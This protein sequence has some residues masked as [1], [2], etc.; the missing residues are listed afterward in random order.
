[1]KP[2]S[3]I[4]LTAALAL[5]VGLAAWGFDAEAEERSP[6]GHETRTQDMKI[7][8]GDIWQKM[9]IDEKVA[10]VWGVGHVVSIEREAAAKYT[11]PKRDSLSTRMATGLAGKPI[12]DIVSS[13]DSYYRENPARLDDPVMNVIWVKLVKPNIKSDT[14]S[15]PV[16]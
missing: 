4:R 16:Q 6:Q 13:V 11:G 3:L 7:L 8:T 12:M 5:A 14:V 9:T 1:M 10:F 15:V 2:H